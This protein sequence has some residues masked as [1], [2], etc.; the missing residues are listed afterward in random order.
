MGS[1]EKTEFFEVVFSIFEL[2][3]DISITSV[4]SKMLS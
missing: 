2:L 3:K 1:L 4:K